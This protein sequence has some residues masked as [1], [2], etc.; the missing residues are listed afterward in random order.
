MS[1]IAKHQPGRESRLRDPPPREPR[2]LLPKPYFTFSFEA[3]LRP[4]LSRFAAACSS[5]CTA[6]LL[7]VSDVLDSRHV[8][9]RPRRPCRRPSYSRR[10]QSRR[11]RIRTRAPPRAR[12]RQTAARWSRRWWQLQ[13]EREFYPV[14]VCKPNLC[15]AGLSSHTAA[16]WSVHS[17]LCIASL[18]SCVVS[19]ISGMLVPQVDKQLE[20]VVSAGLLQRDDFNDRIM[21]A[22]RGMQVRNSLHLC[23]TIAD[24][25]CLP[26]PAVSAQCWAPLCKAGRVPA[27]CCQPRGHLLQ[28]HCPG[29]AVCLL[30]PET[31]M[32]NRRSLLVS[33]SRS[34]RC[35]RCSTSA[36]LCRRSSSAA[37]A[38]WAPT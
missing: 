17:Q 18:A 35:G 8:Q 25:R 10:R 26:T 22:L 7:H 4:L 38:T 37:C 23:I 30:H 14:D 11:H 36:A 24:S 16:C 9:R 32:V 3:L 31:W 27:C 19:V 21:A 20:V 2:S 29:T 33:H 34:E 6:C 15:L 12:R 13:N 1:I 28:Y 5:A